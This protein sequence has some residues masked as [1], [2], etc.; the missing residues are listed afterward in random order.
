MLCFIKLKQLKSENHIKF[1]MTRNIFSCDN[2]TLVTETRRPSDIPDCIFVV[3]IKIFP[4][5]SKFLLT[6][7]D[8]MTIFQDKVDTS[9]QNCYEKFDCHLMESTTI[10]NTRTK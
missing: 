5:R 1:T 3:K 10:R 7:T 2:Q 6:K 8:N 4:A 9:M